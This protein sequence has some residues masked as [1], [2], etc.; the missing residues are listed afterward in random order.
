[1]VKKNPFMAQYKLTRERLAS[2]QKR[3]NSNFNKGVYN[4]TDERKIKKQL[5]KARKIIADIEFI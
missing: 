5:E 4:L 2:S 3:V 1:M